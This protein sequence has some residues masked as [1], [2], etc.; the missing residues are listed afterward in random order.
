MFTGIVT[1]MD[2]YVESKDS[3]EGG[4]IDL[5]KIKMGVKEYQKVLAVGSSVRNV[6]VGDLVCINPSRYA[7]KKYEQNSMKADMDEHYNS[8]IRYNF[9]VVLLDDIECLLLDERDIDFVI[10]EYEEV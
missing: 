7:V 2:K 3:S 6:A 8:V 1:T 5:S 9:N 10:N 4:I